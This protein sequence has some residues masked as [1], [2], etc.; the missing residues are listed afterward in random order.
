MLVIKTPDNN[1]KERK[2]VIDTIFNEF[3]NIEYNSETGS[4]DYEIILPNDNKLIIKDHFFNKYTSDLEYLDIKNLPINISFIENNFI[5]RQDIPI[6]FGDSRLDIE[7]SEQIICGIDIF[8]SIFFMLTRWEEYVKN[9]RDTHNRFPSIESTAY[10]NGFLNRSVVDEYIEMLWNMLVFLGYKENRKNKRDQ[11]FITHDIDNLYKWKSWRHVI[12]VAF[13][14]IIKRKNSSLAKQRLSEYALIRRKKIND[15]YD[16]FD[17][18]MDI[19]EKYSVKSRFYFMSGGSSAYD[20]RY[21]IFDQ[22]CKE[23]LKKIDK[24]GHII[25]F[26]PSYNTYNNISQFRKEKYLLEKILGLEIKEGRGHYLR[27]EVPTTWQIWE[28]CGM[29]ID[30]T[31]GYADKEGFRCGSAEEFNVFNILTRK[32]LKLKERP[33]ILMDT[34]I[35]KY[36]KLSPDIIEDVLKELRENSNIFTVLW[37]NSQIEHINDY[38]QIIN[39]LCKT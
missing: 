26:H 11:I 20:K 27:F 34:S 30:S 18:L 25:G 2:Y 38:E 39:L 3:L 14:D 28:D 4:K 10:Q 19:S 32:K 12:Q 16:T 21:T 6:I 22:K 9:E 24:R 8:S 37:H 31:C 35:Y 1:L 15:P 17:R 13:G 29:E 23:I 33:L 5:I 36:Q 7:E